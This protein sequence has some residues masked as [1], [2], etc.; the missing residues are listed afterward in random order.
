RDFGEME[1]S[2]VRYHIDRMLRGHGTIAAIR[3][4]STGKILE[5]TLNRLPDQSVAVTIF[6]AT[7]RYALN[8]RL[9]HAVEVAGDGFAIY[10][11]QDRIAICSS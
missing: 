7:E 6:D 10:D 4:A 8:R 1:L 11:A 9:R 5:F 2:D 3:H